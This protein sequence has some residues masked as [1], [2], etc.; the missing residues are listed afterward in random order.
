M[1]K[2]EQSKKNQNRI[3]AFLLFTICMILTII[4][5]PDF[6]IRFLPDW[7]LMA[8][9]F[10]SINLPKEF[11]LSTA[12]FLGLITD[13]IKGA[14]LGQHTISSLIIVFATTKYHLQLRSFTKIQLLANVILLSILYHF[15][16]FWINGVA[17]ISSS[18]ESYWGPILGNLITWP[19]INE[20]LSKY[21]IYNTPKK[22]VL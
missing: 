4:P 18:L 13:V 20:I 1:N 12:F 3:I 9:I 8:L 14:I 21:F 6:F 16:L 15:I 19:I 22:E 7:G 5:L 10:L 17:G 2:K 11:N